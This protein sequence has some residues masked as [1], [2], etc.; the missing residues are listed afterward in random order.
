[1]NMLRF[2]LVMFTSLFVTVGCSE[3]EVGLPIE[4]EKKIEEQ[5]NYP[6]PT[7]RLEVGASKVIVPN[8]TKLT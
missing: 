4:I 6:P 7:L 5:V 3:N 2:L 1:M 8:G